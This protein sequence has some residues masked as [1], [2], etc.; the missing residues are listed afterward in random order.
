MTE[1]ISK[2]TKVDILAIEEI[3]TRDLVA[4]NKKI[5]NSDRQVEK[6][7]LGIKL[8]RFT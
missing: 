1:V 5:I 8:K 4:E 7:V 2:K 3:Y 6:E